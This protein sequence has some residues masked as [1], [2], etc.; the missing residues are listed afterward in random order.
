MQ[1]LAR[2]QGQGRYDWGFSL[3]STEFS[4]FEGTSKNMTENQQKAGSLT[5]SKFE[6]PKKKKGSKVP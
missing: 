4:A 3:P 5:K 2:S 1:G 6:S